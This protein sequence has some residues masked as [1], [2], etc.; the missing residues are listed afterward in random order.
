MKDFL[1]YVA[2][3]MINKY[4]TNL[5]DIAVV[6]P[7][8]R[9]SLFLN[10][11]LAR[12]AKKPVWSPHYITISELFRQQSQLMVADPLKLVCD[13]HKSFCKCTR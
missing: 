12:Y 4:D 8:K 10:E 11:H 5:S 7:N 1:A 13:L 3:D 2:E 6:F 9:A